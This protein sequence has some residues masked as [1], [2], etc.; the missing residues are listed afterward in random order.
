VEPPRPQ[1]SLL[2]KGT[3][4][5]AANTDTP[6]PVTLGS[7]DDLP[8]DGRLV[9]FLK[10]NVPSSFPRDEKVELAAADDSFHTVLTLA[11]GSLMLED[12][13][14]AM[15]SVE[16]LARFGSSAFGP[17]HLRAI[18]AD[19]T[20]GDWMPLGTLVRL[21]GFKELRCPRSQAK[22]CILSGTNL[23]LATSVAA[24]PDF[25]NATDVPPDFTGTQLIVP[26]P[27]NGVL[28]CKLRDDPATVQTLTL[29]V[30]LMVQSGSRTPAPQTPP[31]SAPLTAPVAP[32]TPPAAPPAATETQPDTPAA[33]PA[34]PDTQPA[35][36]Q[37]SAPPPAQS[38]PTPAKPGM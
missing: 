19:G 13:K 22:P 26:H 23:F 12:A 30:T 31:S 34:A 14:T 38:A 15:G 27:A 25:D 16:P 32:A 33:V 6:S 20:T 28:Y 2:S 11:D 29:P 21:P 5:E 3:Q 9:F 37:A 10:S 17:L 35:T 36:P 8:V 18:S 7:P 4:N 1:V 24:T